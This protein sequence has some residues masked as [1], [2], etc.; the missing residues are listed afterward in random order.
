MDHIE[1]TTVSLHLTLRIPRL[2]QQIIRYFKMYGWSP[3]WDVP[4]MD[5]CNIVVYNLG[6]H[7]HA[8]SKEMNGIHWS[9]PKYI[10]DF[11]AAITSLVDFVSSRKG[12]AVWRLVLFFLVCS[13]CT[14]HASHAY[15]VLPCVTFYCFTLDPCAASAL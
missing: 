13:S 7:Y 11:R 8:H 9:G 4:F 2:T 5:D 1:E 3:P 12:V 6:L 14:L 10:D 15:C